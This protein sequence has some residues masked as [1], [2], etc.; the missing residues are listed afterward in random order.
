MSVAARV[1][2]RADTS[3]TRPTSWRLLA[4]ELELCSRCGKCR[5]VC[6]VFA[7]SLNEAMVA[8]GRIE[9][10]K[11]LLGGRLRPTRQLA[12][13]LN[14]CVKCL[15]C[16]SVCPSGVDFKLVAE[17]VRDWVSREQLLPLTA[18]IGIET[19]TPH[20]WLFDVAVRAA[21]VLQRFVPPGEGLP[22]RHLPMML[23]G[24]RS[25]PRLASRSILERYRRPVGPADA[26]LTVA[27]FV[28][29]L[30]NYVFTDAA[31]ATIELLTRLGFR[32]V[33]P[34]GQVCCGT[35]A[36]SIGSMRVARSLA[37]RNV[38][39]FEAS[40]ADVVVVTCATGGSALKTEYPDLI[41]EAGRRWAQRTYD[42]SEFLTRF[43]DVS[44]LAVGDE[45]VGEPV[46]YHDPCHLRWVQ[47]VY[48]EPRQL[49][50]RTGPYE[51]LSGAELCCG[52]GGV[53]SLFYPKLSE[54]IARRKL[55][56]LEALRAKT[57][58]TECPGCRLQLEA[59]IGKEGLPVRMKM[60][61][62][63]LRDR[64]SAEGPST[65]EG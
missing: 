62:E 45:R 65:G 52:M 17:A 53:F 57:V 48:E 27:Y 18:R 19:L 58:A 42:L 1:S 29:C 49:L 50:R 32:V 24:V 64:L 13:Y 35:P 22:I 60:L 51:E 5:S 34:S 3:R 21:R 11:A 54:D 2:V 36:L 33:V 4:E 15:R 16:A 28:G 39:Q 41:G 20:R 7:E 6:P 12:R 25:L 37:R 31:E 63:V 30:Q 38:A 9:L 23:Y 56:G 61:A 44:E 46:S 14:S 8:R 26:P 47:G 40:G 55:P 43:A 10:L 59:L